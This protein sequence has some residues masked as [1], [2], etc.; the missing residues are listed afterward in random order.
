MGA[1]RKAKSWAHLDE[2]GKRRHIG[3]N[4][5]HNHEVHITKSVLEACLARGDLQV[6]GAQEDGHKERL[7]KLGKHGYW[8]SERKYYCALGQI[9]VLEKEPGLKSPHFVLDIF[10]IAFC[11]WN[12]WRRL[13]ASLLNERKQFLAFVVWFASHDDIDKEVGWILMLDTGEPFGLEGV[14]SLISRPVVCNLS[15]SQKQDFIK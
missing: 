9:S 3:E 2:K 14:E 12:Q 6:E 5:V 8:G 11:Q 1:F 15:T 10:L 7:A 4:L 13:S